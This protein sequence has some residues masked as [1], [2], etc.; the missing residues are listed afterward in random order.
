MI[1]KADLLQRAREWQLTPEVVEKDYVLGWLLAGIASHPATRNNWVFK[2]GTCLKKCVLETYRFSEDLDFTLLPGAE[3]SEAGVETILREI[4]AQVTTFSGI[5]FAASGLGV[6]GR[7]DLAGRPTLEGR[8]EYSGP[9]VFPGSPKI[10]LDLTQHEPV[11]RPPELRPVFHP[12]PDQLPDDLRVTMYAIG[13]LVAEKTRALCERMRPRDLYDGVLLGATSRSDAD[14]HALRQVAIEK[15][16]IK[17]MTLPAIADVM[18]RAAIDEELRSEWDSMLGH[19]LP[20][21]P[22]LDDFLARLP[23]AIAWMQE[24]NAPMA[25][26]AAT[27]ATPPRRVLSPLPA[28]PG[29]VLVVERGIRTWGVAAPLEAIRY[30][31]ASHLLVEFRYHDAVRRIEPYSLRRP[32]T[33]NLLLYG[34]EQLKN[35]SH[36]NGVRAYKVAEIDQVRILNMSFAPRYAI[37]LTER[38]GVWRW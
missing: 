31:G 24:P 20:A 15:F 5:Q 23:D 29:E 7:K 19:Q 9:L 1:S 17:G 14:A 2:G 13:E 34:F 28:T 3:Y 10:R 30:A 32:K 33:G 12:Y 6:K 16:A 37:E 4:V 21:T 26:R 11:L 38:G 18:S 22:Q 8:I 27:T 36:T 35:G 25:T